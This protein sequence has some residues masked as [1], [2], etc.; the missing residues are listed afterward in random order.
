MTR[1]A[2]PSCVFNI[3]V[4]FMDLFGFPMI[5]SDVF[6]TIQMWKRKMRN[7]FMCPWTYPSEMCW[8]HMFERGALNELSYPKAFKGEK[9]INS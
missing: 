7:K 4:A 2:L 9:L 8:E 3:H 1:R 5:L 6:P